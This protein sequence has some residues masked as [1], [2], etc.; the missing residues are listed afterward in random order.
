MS[1]AIPDGA[2]L[3][4]DGPIVRLGFNPPRERVP[5]FEIVDLATLHQRR[6]GRHGR[7]DRVHRV[8]F[9]T[10]TLVTEGSGEHAVDFV[11]FPLRPG[12]LLWVRPGQVQSFVRPGTADGIHLLFTPAFPARTDGADRL[13]HAWHGPACRHLGTGPAYGTLSTLLGQLRE[14]YGRPEPEVSVEILRLLLTTVLLQI[15]RLPGAEG[16]ADPRAGGETYARFRAELERS[17]ATTRRAA[18]YA[19]RLGYTLKTLT[20]ACA[21]ATGQPVKHVI[22]GRVALEARRLLAHTDEPVAAIGR[23][24]GFP[25][26]TNFGKFFT[27]HAGV[28]P[29]DFRRSHR[30]RR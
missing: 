8:D 9:H 15:E 12:T 16:G 25:E 18:D 13:T 1:A 6:R 24:L 3:I 22:D 23:R 14:E 7:A 28:T 26:P 30:T 11:S 5:G 10:F 19:Q 29:G 2:A 4:G 20:R 17:Y 21:A 27:R